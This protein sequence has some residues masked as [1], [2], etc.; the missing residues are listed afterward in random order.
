MRFHEEQVLPATK[1]GAGSPSWPDPAGAAGAGRVRSTDG[2]LSR[3]ELEPTS[4]PQSVKAG[5][6]GA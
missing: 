2:L 5:A 6:P 4:Q 3:A 1:S